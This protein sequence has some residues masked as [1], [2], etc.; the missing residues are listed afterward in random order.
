MELL[1]LLAVS[2]LAVISAVGTVFVLVVKALGSQGALGRVLASILAFFGLVGV[3]GLGLAGL[4]LLLLG[5]GAA[6]LIESGPV[7]SVEVLR[8][9]AVLSDAA[10]AT[11]ALPDG[12]LR[13]DLDRRYEVHLLVTCDREV[14]PHRLGLWLEARTG[15]RI[16]LVDARRFREDG[17]DCVFLDLGIE[18]SPRD[19][20][21]FER[22]LR[23]ELP[24]FDLPEGV[25][26]ELR[27][28]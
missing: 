20:Q 26:L 4:G 17:R 11:Q 2:A 22:E 13:G 12:R 21:R 9:E 8:T 18:V 7:R 5:F 27:S 10:L 1:F 25:R 15:G 14:D 3:G 24:F 16:D 19:L 6:R 23:R 28:S